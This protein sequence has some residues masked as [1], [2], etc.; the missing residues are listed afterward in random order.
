MVL[1]MQ[2]KP[3]QAAPT[4]FGK[5]QEQ[6]SPQQQERGRMTNQTARYDAFVFAESS[7]AN[8]EFV[9]S[10]RIA[11]A[12]HISRVADVVG[13]SRTT[14]RATTVARSPN[15]STMSSRNKNLDCARPAENKWQKSR[16][17]TTMGSSASSGNVSNI[18]NATRTT[19]RAARGLGMRK[20]AVPRQNPVASE[21]AA[22]VLN[23][24]T[25]SRSIQ[26]GTIW[27]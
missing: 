10:Q 17:K 9:E 3:P 26:R 14:K 13:T 23:R 24:A 21:A 4:G 12:T 6:L 7:V 2:R 8:C 18:S 22:A 25:S 16:N 1:T 11:A 5:G 27:K 19:A 15:F 20:P